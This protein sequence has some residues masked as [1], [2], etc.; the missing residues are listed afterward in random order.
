MTFKIGDDVEIL[1]YY[2][3]ALSERVYFGTITE[4]D[5]TIFGTIYYIPSVGIWF[6]EKELKHV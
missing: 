4:I 1:D 5:T 3:Y 2:T 6:T